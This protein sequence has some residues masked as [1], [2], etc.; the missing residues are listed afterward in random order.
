MTRVLYLDPFGGAAGDM[1]LAALLDVG[2]NEERLRALL[3]GLHVPGWHLDVTS[4]RQQG[5]AGRRVRVDVAR[6]SYP[7]R[8]LRDVET[9]LGQAE[10]PTS[11]AERSRAVFRRLFAAEAEVHGQPVDDVHLHEAAAVDAVVDIVG[12]CVAVELL[13]VS[14][15][16]C[17]PVPVGRGTVETAHGLLPVP[18]PAVAAMLRG[19]PL[20]SHGADGEMTTPTGAALLVTLADEFGPPPGGRLLACGVG[21]GT[22]RFVAIPNLLRALLLASEDETAQAPSM[23]VVETT[24]DDVTGEGLA[25]FL[26]RVLAAGAVDAWCLPGTGRKGRPM[27]ELRALCTRDGANEVAAALFAEGATLGVRLVPCRRPELERRV[28]PVNT[29]YGT[30]RVK[31]GAFRGRVVSVK[32]EHEDCRGAAERAGLPLT[33]V[34]TAAR[35]ASPRPGEVWPEAA[36]G[37]VAQGDVGEAAP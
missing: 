9:L 19:V 29:P 14:R 4:D 30:I 17:G 15:V 2:A 6:E 24:L 25:F 36:G 1:L 18:P 22:R 8:R 26:E 27:A 3:A 16:V 5:F 10:L 23:T 33:V 37:A 20:A 13:E 32:P 12:T 11:V 31:V 7:A 21:L 34:E 28:I 35:V